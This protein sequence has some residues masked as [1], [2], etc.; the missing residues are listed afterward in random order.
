[1]DMSVHVDR[2]RPPN[3][4]V[5]HDPRRRRDVSAQR[6]VRDVT[7][8]H[9][10]N[11]EAGGEAAGGSAH[12]VAVDHDACRGAAV[13]RRSRWR[14]TYRP[15]AQ[16]RCAVRSKAWHVMNG[17]VGQVADSHRN[18]LLPQSI[19]ERRQPVA[20]GSNVPISAGRPRGGRG[21]RGASERARRIGAHSVVDKVDGDDV[22]ADRSMV[23]VACGVP[24]R[25]Q[26]ATAA[27]G[28]HQRSRGGTRS[29]QLARSSR[30]VGERAVYDVSRRAVCS[31][32]RG[33]HDRAP[34]EK[35][36]TRRPVTS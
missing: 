22:R 7:D 29:R 13:Q 21:R 33:R 12:D 24:S 35:R 30:V 25:A 27:H 10:F 15:P 20:Q 8:H 17:L 9:P 28:R 32:R 1:M 6:D 19:N 34:A 26:Y 5:V 2:D 11:A 23:S 16:G 3:A 31:C 14:P 36:C 18:T 4:T